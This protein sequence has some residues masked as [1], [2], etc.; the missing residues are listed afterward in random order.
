MSMVRQ[1]FAREASECLGTLETLPARLDAGE[2]EPAELHRVARLLRGSA[3]MAREEAVVRTAGSLEATGRALAEGRLGWNPELASRVRECVADLRALL[4]GEE[5]AASSSPGLP[6]VAASRP[7]APRPDTSEVFRAFAAREAE[8]IRAEVDSALQELLAAPRDREPL[9][10]ILRRQRALAG[11]A[12]LSTLP[13]LAETLTAVDDITRL[14]ARLDIGVKSEWMD[15]YRAARDV[16]AA[17]SVALHKGEEIQ[18]VPA[19]SRLRHIR[20]ELLDRYGIEEER[21]NPPVLPLE[22]VALVNGHEEPP[23]SSSAVAPAPNVG[24]AEPAKE[25]LAAEAVTEAAE[26]PVVAA[27]PPSEP[28]PVPLA[29]SHPAAAA[30]GAPAGADAAGAP[31]SQPIGATEEPSVAAVPSPAMSPSPAA[32]P[33]PAAGPSPAAPPSPAAASAADAAEANEAAPPAATA[34][35]PLEQ[36]FYQG[37]G[38]LR[39]ALELRESLERLAEADPRARELVDEVFDL[40]ELALP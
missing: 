33:S 22:D 24:I 8:A 37:E 4:A 39:R 2:A 29:S 13:I 30:D 28:A 40:I 9:R 38:A 18:Q 31:L 1:F 15:A 7:P 19:L 10:R 6:D 3:Q 26:E 32:A 36:F 5:R 11:A 21:R 34:P 14:V 20:E 16:L 23:A 27:E 17:A 35:I 25:S 12:R